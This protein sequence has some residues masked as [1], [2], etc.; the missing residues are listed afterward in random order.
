M[1]PK[2]TAPQGGA[3]EPVDDPTGH[4]V[5]GATARDAVGLDATGPDGVGR[6][7]MDQGAPD[8]IA[9]AAAGRAAPR[10][11]ATEAE[12]R[13]LASAIRLRIMRLCLDRPLTNKEIAERL[14]AN[15]A[16]TLHHVRTL[17]AT[18]FLAAQKERRGT[19]GAR[20]VP[21]LATGKSWTLSVHDHR[22]DGSGRAMLDAFLEEIAYIDIDAVQETDDPT[23]P[24][25]F[26]RLGLRLPPKDLLELGDRMAALLNEYA[27]RPADMTDGIPYSIFLAFYRDVTR[28]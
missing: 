20:E 2:S 14:G 3:G 16:T 5:D 1:P 17:V 6:D 7:A 24:S 19:R 12:A 8:Y 23:D 28:P 27:I 25:G 26:S 22:I 18:G 21:Y 15:P 4:A 13:A 10:R 9:A 11:P